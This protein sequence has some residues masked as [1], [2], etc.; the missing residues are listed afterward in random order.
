MTPDKTIGPAEPTPAAFAGTGPAAQAKR[1]VHATRPKFFPA[2]VL[3]VLVGTTWGACVAQ[4]FD[5]AVF[6]LALL[7]TV[8]VHAAANVLNDVG[9]DVSG[10]DRINE[11][12]IFP[13]TGGSRFIQNGILSTRAM[14]VWGIQ[15]LLAAAAI[16]AV[17]TYL[18]GPTVLVFGLVGIA[19]ATLY[20]LPKVELAA[21]GIGEASVAIAFGVLPVS[22]AAWL[23]SGII[24]PASILISIPVSIWVAAILLINEVPDL[25]ADAAAGKRT[26]VVRLGV[27]GTRRLYLALQV[28]AILSFLAAGALGF[29]P[30]WASL[31]SLLLVPG[32]LKATKGINES[33]NRAALTRSIEATLGLHTIGCAL[34]IVATLLG[35]IF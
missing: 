7:A 35:L 29:L 18:R 3:P 30:W 34:L 25:A 31:V 5:V 1:L 14:A 2:S 21:R 24:D 11:G 10:T 15:L 16:G 4:S 17:L 20:S 19:L 33:G 28:T 27:N 32:V 8:C 22:G 26:L 12:R 23:Q 9:D 6:L 13:Y